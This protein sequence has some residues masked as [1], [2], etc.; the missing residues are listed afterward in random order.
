[1]ICYLFWQLLRYYLISCC[2]VIDQFIPT[3]CV[4]QI[5][6]NPSQSAKTFKSSSV[7]DTS[8]SSPPLPPRTY[9][10]SRK[11]DPLFDCVPPPASASGFPVPVPR[12]SLKRQEE[13][14]TV[15][16]EEE[17]SSVQLRK[18][19]PPPASAPNPPVRSS[20]SPVFTTDSHY[21]WSL[22]EVSERTCLHCRCLTSVLLWYRMLYR[23]CWPVIWHRMYFRPS[24]CRLCHCVQ[25]L[26]L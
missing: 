24:V 13:V 16:F 7:G 17:P 22:A 18:L 6:R 11:Q 4:L 19:P 1:M 14:S 21:Y 23:Q 26:T 10:P 8:L 25:C 3:N 2:Q 20:S 15:L 5:K 12:T 9:L